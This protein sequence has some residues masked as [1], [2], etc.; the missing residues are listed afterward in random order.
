[1]EIPAG[2]MSDQGQDVNVRLDALVRQ[3]SQLG[4]IVVASTPNGQV[5][6]RD[7]A[8][9]EDGVKTVQVIN[10]VNGSPAVT[11]TATKAAGANMIDVS[12]GV[13]QAMDDVQPS[14]PAGMR[15]DV[16]WN[17]ATYAQQSFA[18]IRKTLVEAI[19]FTGLIL[20][21]FLHTWRSTLIVLV[22]IPTSL[23]TSFCLMGV[24]GL[25]LDLL[26]M[27]AVT[28]SVG[29]LV[30]DSI[31]I[32]ENISRHLGMREP[33]VVAA[34]RGRSE[35]GLAAITITLV[36]VAV[37]LPL[38][39]LPGLAGEFIRPFALVI[40]CA[41]LTSLVVSF[42]LTPLLA[43]RLLGLGGGSD[44]SPTPTPPPSPPSLAPGTAVST[45][46]RAGTAASCTP[47]SS[48]GSCSSGCAGSSSRSGWR[49][50]PRGS[51]C[52]SRAASAS[53]SSRAATRARWT[54][55]SPCR[56]P[57]PWPRPTRWSGRWR[58]SCGRCPR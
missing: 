32:L 50:S 40:A 41:T 38:A 29:I 5:L 19:L 25:G 20:L 51:R 9:I 17:S 30:D 7:V 13:R 23:L 1:M 44:R 55:R 39:L 8:T 12:R 26:S 11:M 3:P 22:S 43:S 21:L 15:L 56:P 48:E 57:R 47:C 58:P 45:R 37:Y 16:V 53:T 35:I 31:V 36:D 27:L 33:P 46:W 10:R 34:L 2:T 54:S 6:L 42:T 14:L 49:A 52:P 4:Q 24:L 28:L 18:M